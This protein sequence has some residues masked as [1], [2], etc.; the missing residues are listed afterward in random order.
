MC[1]P[2]VFVMV[3]GVMVSGPGVMLNWL[4]LFVLLFYSI[5]PYGGAARAKSDFFETYKY[6]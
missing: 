3:N 5:I 2:F 1:I 4:L 6:R